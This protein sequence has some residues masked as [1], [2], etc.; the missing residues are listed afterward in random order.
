MTE[1]STRTMISKKVLAG[2]G[3][4]VCKPG[5]LSKYTSNPYKPYMV[6]IPI[7]SLL[8]K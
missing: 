2:L 8:T 3:F 6:I 1:K 5:G 4:R 7:I